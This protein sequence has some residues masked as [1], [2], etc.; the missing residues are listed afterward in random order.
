MDENMIMLTQVIMP[1]FHLFTSS[2]IFHNDFCKTLSYTLKQ[3]MIKYVV[4][5]HENHT[6]GP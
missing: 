2:Y 3:Q 6:Y 4:K 5:T 1:P